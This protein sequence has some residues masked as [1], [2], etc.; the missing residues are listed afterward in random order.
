[1]KAQERAEQA[2]REL[3]AAKGLLAEWAQ[4]C[5][6]Y[7]AEITNL[8]SALRVCHGFGCQCLDCRQE[9][10]RQRVAEEPT[11]G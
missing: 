5:G 6:D 7:Q 1:M 10:N 2:E 4:K 8:R 11:D 3:D 9:R